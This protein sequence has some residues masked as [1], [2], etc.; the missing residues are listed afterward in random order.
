MEYYPDNKLSEV[1][2]EGKT[3]P[4]LGIA[5]TPPIIWTVTESHL[6]G[7]TRRSCILLEQKAHVSGMVNANKRPLLQC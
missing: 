5:V 1:K 4:S 7:G 6:K 3:F 2:S